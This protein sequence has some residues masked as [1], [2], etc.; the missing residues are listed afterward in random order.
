MRYRWL[1]DVNGND[2]DFGSFQGRFANPNS[3]N[4]WATDGTR[5]LNVRHYLTPANGYKA[6]QAD[7]LILDGRP[8]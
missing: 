4:N 5:Q 8:I 6:S 3:N 7:D 1:P 2:V